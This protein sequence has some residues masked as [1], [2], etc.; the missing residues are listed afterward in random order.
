MTEHFKRNWDTINEE[1]LDKVVNGGSLSQ[2][3]DR[4]RRTAKDY[5]DRATVAK[6]AVIA[7]NLCKAWQ[8]IP[9]GGPNSKNSET[10]S[11]L[12]AAEQQLYDFVHDDLF[13][14]AAFENYAK[15]A[16]LSR[17][18]VVHLIRRP[19]PLR[20][21][22]KK[23]PIHI[24]TIRAKC[25]LPDLW[26][27]HRTVGVGHL[28]KPEYFRLLGVSDKVEYA[29]RK[30]QNIRN[31]IHF[32]GPNFIGYGPGLYEGLIDLRDTILR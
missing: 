13:I 6:K 32:G 23:R 14:I 26:F 8:L 11:V 31:Q 12:R 19:N 24:N 29:I 18:Y 25:N 9:D 7:L 22:Q 28:L 17:R 21:K 1:F 15:A 16:L 4:L 20:N 10:A 27:E 5:I 30:C 3:I 2:Q